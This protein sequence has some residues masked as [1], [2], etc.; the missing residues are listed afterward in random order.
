M[1]AGYGACIN[2]QSG[3]FCTTQN[4]SMLALRGPEACIL[5]HSCTPLSAV[6]V[7]GRTSH[8][9][10]GK[11]A[12][13]QSLTIRQTSAASHELICN[14]PVGPS[15]NAASAGA[16]LSSSAGFREPETIV[17]HSLKHLT[18]PLPGQHSEGGAVACTIEH[19]HN[20][21]MQGLVALAPNL[22]SLTVVGHYQGDCQVFQEFR[23]LSEL[24]VCVGGL[25]R[26]A[27]A[28][29]LRA[30]PFEMQFQPDHRCGITCMCTE[31]WSPEQ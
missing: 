27:P 26:S 22:E 5:A 4:R 21:F 30:A 8:G 1:S 23:H 18:T 3:V 7:S 15:V 24:H 2:D 28:S 25:L 12:R 11:L 19:S 10:Y 20:T 6:Q 29:V 13:L 14:L 9:T 17:M 16:S 31:Q